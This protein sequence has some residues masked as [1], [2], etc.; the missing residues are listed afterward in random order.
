MDELHDRASKLRRHQTVAEQKLWF[1]LRDRR[2]NGWKFR[3]Q[4]PIAGYIVDFV[5]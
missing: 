2:L 3:R 4:K 1:Y 5:Y